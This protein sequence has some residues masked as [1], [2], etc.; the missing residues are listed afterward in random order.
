MAFLR[1]YWA[2]IVGGVVLLALIIPN[3]ISRVVRQAVK[4]LSRGK[5]VNA[6]W[7]YDKATGL[8][9]AEPKALAD[10]AGV[11]QDVFSLATM[12]SSEHGNDPQ[13]YKEAVGSVAL[14][15]AKARGKSITDLLL[16]VKN[17]S[18]AGFYGSQADMEKTTS[19]GG[20]ASDRYA[21]TSKP[22]YEDDIGI[23]SDL[24]AGNTPDPTNGARQFDSPRAQDAGFKKGLYSMDADALAAK[25]QGEGKTEVD[26]DGID[27][28]RL[29][30]WTTKEA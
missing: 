30:F 26:V 19:K 13:V 1:K 25:R 23:A 20:H 16:E 11:T 3:P 4:F 6:D 7:P 8:V 2:W 9:N 24:I 18:H 5:R 12:L 27:P 22:P 14:N 21:A 15:E 17:P 29:R 28:Y 10:E